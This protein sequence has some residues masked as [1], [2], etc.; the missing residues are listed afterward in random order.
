MDPAI[1]QLLKDVETARRRKDYVDMDYLANQVAKLLQ[2]DT[3]SDASR[4]RSRLSY[5]KHMAAF[6]QAEVHLQ[7]AKAHAETAAQEADRGGDPAAGLYAKMV[8]GG[9]TLPALR[10]GRIAIELL[11]QVCDDA[12]KL[13]A[14][15]TD[16][17]EKSRV[18][19]IIMNCYW[20]RILLA[21]EYRG[22]KNDV[23]KWK[24]ALESNLVFQQYRTTVGAKALADAQ[25]YIDTP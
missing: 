15:T 5:E 10:E 25:A 12:E 14:A 19:R 3:S 7:A 11:A 8:L 16:A 4:S 17:S 23:Q 2:N 20:H 6:Q 18:E 22:D 21:L 1:E 9:H 24:T 13:F